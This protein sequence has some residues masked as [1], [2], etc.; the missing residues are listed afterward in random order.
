[1]NKVAPEVTGLQFI[2]IQ[3]GLSLIEVARAQ[4]YKLQTNLSG[5]VNENSQFTCETTINFSRICKNK[6]VTYLKVGQ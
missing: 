6:A 5:I 3:S 4:F 1:M 2:I